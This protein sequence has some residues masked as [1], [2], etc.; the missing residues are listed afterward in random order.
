MRIG[1]L[2]LF[3]VQPPGAGAAQRSLVL[4]LVCDA[5]WEG[6][7]ET[8]TTLRPDDLPEARQ[9]LTAA[10]AE[11]HVAD[12]EDLAALEVIAQLRLVS[13]VEMACWDALARSASLPLCRLWGGCFRARVPVCR[14]LPLDRHDSSAG[15]I[16][17]A[18]EWVEQGY[19][20]LLVPCANNDVSANLRRL[21]TLRA[22]IADGVELRIDGESRFSRRQAAELATGLSHDGFRFL[23]DLLAEPVAGS[24][25]SLHAV[26]HSPLALGRS[27][28][29]PR[30]VFAAAPWVQHFV[31]YPERMSEGW[32]GV[33]RA[34]AVAEAAGRTASLA[35]TH[36]LGL[37]TAALLHLAAATPCLAAAHDIGNSPTACSILEEPLETQDGML[38]VPLGAGLGVEPDRARLESFQIG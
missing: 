24:L 29:G 16:Q 22:A 32:R 1:D 23:L 30:Q 21:D 31:L 34:A 10:L 26:S 25:E 9:L 28:A 33:R 4:R 20:S 5:G 14:H 7:G 11:R 13:A 2:E 6:W 18:R 8:L 12:I 36:S 15:L 35:L 17:Q 19:H 27:L 37:A 3:M 38:S